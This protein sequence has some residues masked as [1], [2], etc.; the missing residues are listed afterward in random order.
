[1]II[2]ALDPPASG[3]HEVLDLS[4]IEHDRIEMIQVGPV[5]LE[6]VCERVEKTFEEVA[7]QRYLDFAV[8]LATDVPP[9]IVTDPHRLQQILDS[10]LLNAFTFTPEGAVSLD[11]Y[12]TDKGPPGGHG[13]V[14]HRPTLAFT[15]T[16]TGV[17][18][19]WDRQPVLFETSTSRAHGGLAVSRELARLLGGEIQLT[20]SV[21]RGSAFTLLLPLVLPPAEL[22]PRAPLPDRG[23]R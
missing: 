4:R 6:D 16:D 9:T 17:G 20:S 22:G 13:L 11:V 21:G 23:A 8:R 12:L 3:V 14:Q 2:D 15:V 7:L 19:P 18:V 10:L 1:M 5:V